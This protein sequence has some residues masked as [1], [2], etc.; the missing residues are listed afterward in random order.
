M[1]DEIAGAH[2]GW[3]HYQGRIEKGRAD[4]RILPFA[5]WEREKRSNPTGI[6]ALSSDY[7]EYR[8]GIRFNS[9]LL[10]GEGTGS[11]GGSVNANLFVEERRERRVTEGSESSIRTIQAGVEYQP[12]SLFRNRLDVGWRQTTSLGAD[13]NEKARDA[14]IVSLDGQATAGRSHRFRWFYQGQSERSATLQEIYIRTGQERGLF[15]WKDANGDD[16]IQLD[17]F[18]PETTPGEGEYV[19]TF[20]P[21][22][23]LESVTSVNASFRYEHLPVRSGSR[24]Q[25]IRVRLFFEVDEK[26]RADS[27]SDLYLLQQSSFRVA[28]NTIRG[29]VRLGQTVSLLPLNR[30]SDVDLDMQQIR[31]MSDLASGLET[32]K[33]Q[34][35]S[36]R[37]RRDLGSRWSS[38]IRLSRSKEES[39]SSR[40]L[41]RSFEIQSHQII[42]AFTFTVTNNMSL[43]TSTHFSEKTDSKS[44]STSR[45]F[46]LPLDLNYAAASR[47][48]VRAGIERSSVVVEGEL[49]GLQSFEMTDGRGRGTSWLWQTAL[50]ANLTDVVRATFGYSGRAPSVGDVIHTGRVQLSARF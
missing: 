19:R 42:P 18:I 50:E 10:S 46:R 37:L 14:L 25:Q 48:T 5:E 2:S 28:G 47:F 44:S 8:A 15:V 11:A 31:T 20:F 34:I 36:V 35:Y 12:G 23:S 24:L 33:N 45:V 6:Q 7:D 1:F 32:G 3:V 9:R 17:E 27:R 26:S 40:F 41:S 43:T 13:S 22:D 38:N 39:A 30:T 21:G 49:S 16:V 29:K 4:S